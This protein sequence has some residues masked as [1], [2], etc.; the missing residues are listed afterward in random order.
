M[1]EKNNNISN[2]N[3]KNHSKSSPTEVEDF[4]K[5]SDVSSKSEVDAFLNKVNA[6]TQKVSSQKRGRLIF[7]MD[8]TA[9]R[10]RS[11]DKACHL[12]SEMFTETLGL[13]GLEIQLAYY[14]G[15]GQF[16]STRW[17]SETEQLL[18]EMSDVRCAGGQTQIQKVLQQAIKETGVNRVHA[19][20]FIGDAFEEDIDL[21]CHYAGQLGALG[22]RAFCFQEGND[23]IAKSGFQQIARLTDGAYSS[24]DSSSANQLKELLKAVAVYAAGGLK[25]LE[26]YSKGKSGIA[27]LLT[28]QI[29]K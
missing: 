22:V 14:K 26:E 21:I 25:K 23:P 13:G 19:L 8:A 2:F 4:L 28:N 17:I 3:N 24:F 29:K 15:F 27:Q 9:S 10:E 6:L 7:G 20:V 1:S 18:Q 12:Q 5:R 16:Y 11:W